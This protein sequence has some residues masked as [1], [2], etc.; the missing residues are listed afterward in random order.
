MVSAIIT[1][2][3]DPPISTTTRGI[4]EP[5]PL[6]FD[7]TRLVQDYFVQTE[8]HDLHLCPQGQP[9]TWTL[10]TYPWYAMFPGDATILVYDNPVGGKTWIKVGSQFYLVHPTAKMLKEGDWTLT[11]QLKTTKRIW[12]NESL[13]VYLKYGD[14]HKAILHWQPPKQ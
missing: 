2:S 9:C 5:T 3:N 7:Q 4:E 13:D 6:D 1:W 12:W 14:G 8:Q 11:F 10:V